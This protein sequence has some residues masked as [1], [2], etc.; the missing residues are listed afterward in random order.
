MCRV[1]PIN[2]KSLQYAG[3]YINHRLLT[4]SYEPG[5]RSIKIDNKKYDGGYE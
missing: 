3:R 1:D 4:V 2:Q 5:A